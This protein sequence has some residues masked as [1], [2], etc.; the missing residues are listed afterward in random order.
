MKRKAMLMGMA[1]MAG[2]P[3][4]ATAKGTAKAAGETHRYAGAQEAQVPLQTIEVI[5]EPPTSVA[6][7][8]ADSTQGRAAALLCKI[9]AVLRTSNYGARVTPTADGDGWN[10]EVLEGQQVGYRSGDVQPRQVAPVGVA[11]RLAF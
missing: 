9:K 3:G 1:V 11:F 10:M 7:S 4:W 8:L 5:N 6:G 2:M